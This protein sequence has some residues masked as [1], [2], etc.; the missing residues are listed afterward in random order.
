MRDSIEIMGSM[1]ESKDADMGEGEILAI[2]MK[3]A[4][5]RTSKYE[6]EVEEYAGDGDA[7]DF[8]EPGT[9]TEDVDAQPLVLAAPTGE[10]SIEHPETPLSP[11]PITPSKLHHKLHRLLLFAFQAALLILLFLAWTYITSIHQRR[12]K[13]ESTS[14]LQ[15]AGWSVVRRAECSVAGSLLVAGIGGFLLLGGELFLESLVPVDVCLLVFCNSRAELLESVSRGFVRA[16]ASE[17]NRKRDGSGR[18]WEG[19]NPAGRQAG[20]ASSVVV[21]WRMPDVAV[22]VLLSPARLF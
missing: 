1:G 20:A 5:A 18:P 13:E 3:E 2:M 6:A 19:D 15:V 8:L 17:Q 9:R 16:E 4:M 12:Q 10:S 11:A 7:K 22:G 14:D 21:I